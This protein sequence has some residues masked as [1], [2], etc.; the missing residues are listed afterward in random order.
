MYTMAYAMALRVLNS[1]H[2]FYFGYWPDWLQTLVK[3]DG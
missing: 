1:S 3:D 2:I